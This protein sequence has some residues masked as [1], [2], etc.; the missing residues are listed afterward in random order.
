MIEIS[1]VK[2]HSPHQK[3]KKQKGEND[4]YLTLYD[5]SIFIQ[6]IF[7]FLYIYYAQWHFD[8]FLQYDLTTLS[9]NNDEA[10][11]FQY[12]DLVMYQMSIENTSNTIKIISK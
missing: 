11:T 5:T 6:F 3:K 4:I 10:L 8:K 12:F 2:N 1:H 9:Q 7:N